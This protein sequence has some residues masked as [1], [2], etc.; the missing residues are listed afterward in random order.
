MYSQSQLCSGSILQ[1]CGA[2]LCS[3]YCQGAA[4]LGKGHPEVRD[5]GNLPACR[6]TRRKQ[7]KRCFDTTFCHSS[8]ERPLWTATALQTGPSCTALMCR[9]KV[10]KT[11]LTHHSSAPVRMRKAKRA[12][13]QNLAL[14][15]T[16]IKINQLHTH[17][18]T[19]LAAQRNIDIN[20]PG[21]AICT[22]RT[23]AQSAGSGTQTGT[24]FSYIESTAFIG[25]ASVD[26]HT[27][28]VQVTHFKCC[29]EARVEEGMC[30]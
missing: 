4:S 18:M 24:S 9:A 23:D 17:A 12:N 29:P 10:I 1:P 6:A 8:H 15:A 22:R 7:A 14:P 25:M 11:N 28:F 2:H 26:S 5:N 16:S 20:N 27:C 13:R 21:G 19:P 3:G 30:K